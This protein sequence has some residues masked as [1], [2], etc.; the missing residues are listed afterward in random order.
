L[1]KKGE[2]F[3]LDKAKLRVGRLHKVQKIGLQKEEKKRGDTGTPV[4]S[5]ERREKEGGKEGW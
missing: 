3:E 5:G 4:E 1:G 2:Q